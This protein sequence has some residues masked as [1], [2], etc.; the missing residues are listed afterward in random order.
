MDDSQFFKWMQ[1]DPEK[2]R[3]LEETINVLNSDTDIGRS[4][5]EEYFQN[6]K[7]PNCKINIIKSL[8]PLFHGMRADVDRFGIEKTRK[9]WKYKL[10]VPFKK[11]KKLKNIFNSEQAK[12]NSEVRRRINKDRGEEEKKRITVNHYVGGDDSLDSVRKRSYNKQV[13][14]E[15]GERKTLINT[16]QHKVK[17]TAPKKKKRYS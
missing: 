8:D 9:K 15:W 3:I 11:K 1:S 7:Y 6:D 16:L 10:G 5:R 4:L 17:I 12:I 14:K 2:R 13:E